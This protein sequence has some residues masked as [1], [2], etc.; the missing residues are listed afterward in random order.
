MSLWPKWAS[1]FVLAG[2]LL[3]PR[4]A[5]LFAQPASAPAPSQPAT[6]WPHTLQSDG[7]SVT[8]YQPQVISWPDHKTLNA[9]AAIAIMPPGANTPILG[10]IEVAV[11]TQTDFDTRLV[12]L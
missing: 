1:L 7:A 2:L 9:R 11:Q 6:N 12:I 5:A 3:C 8:V 10:T 4:P